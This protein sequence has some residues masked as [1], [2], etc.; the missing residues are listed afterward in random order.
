MK[1]CF[2]A[3]LIIV[4]LFCGCTNDAKMVAFT[5]NGVKVS[6]EELLFFMR[7]STD[8]I[9]ATA[10]EDYGL[11]ST[12]E[13]FWNESIGDTTPLKLLQETAE[14]EIV[15]SKVMQLTA[16]KYGINSS[17]T[18]G[19]QQSDWEKDNNERLRQE[20]AGELVYGATLRSFYTYLSLV[21]S[22]VENELKQSL[23]KDGTIKV[24][25]QEMKKFYSTHPEYFMGEN[26]GYDSNK[27]NI[28]IWIF[29]EKF[30]KY[31]DELVE[32]SE[33]E[34]QNMDISPDLLY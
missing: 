14:K 30:E 33:I 3:L 7:R 22:E 17:L 23:I 10:E 8:A 25:Q 6:R 29:N 34:Y 28:E 21:L 26:S 4:M 11:D 19:E 15:R 24:T 9:I 2:V 13:A 16:K 20:Q 1:K 18:Y 5:V 27:Q 31:L 32:K 12:I